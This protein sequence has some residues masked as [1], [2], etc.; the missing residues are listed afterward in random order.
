LN[1]VPGSKFV[2]QIPAEEWGLLLSVFSVKKYFTFLERFAPARRLF[3]HDMLKRHK[4]RTPDGRIPTHC[5][6]NSRITRENHALRNTAP[7]PTSRIPRKETILCLQTLIPGLARAV[8]IGNRRSQN[9]ETK[10]L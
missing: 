6:K 7:Q 1:A 10:T 3:V 2:P 8:L 5:A 9:A 4:C